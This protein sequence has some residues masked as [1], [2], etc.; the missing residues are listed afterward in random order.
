MTAI[1]QLPR[2]FPLVG[3]VVLSTGQTV[4]RALPA[5]T[6]S[7]YSAN[8]S[9]QADV[10]TTAARSTKHT[11]PVTA[12][13]TGRFP[14]IYLGQGISYDVTLKDS[15]GATIYTAEDIDGDPADAGSSVS[16]LGRTVEVGSIVYHSLQ[17]VPLGWLRIK[18]D[19]QALLKSSY[20]ELNTKYAA[21]GYPYGSA[22]TTFNI[23]GGAGLHVR[24]WDDTSTWDA[25][26][27]ARTTHA[28]G[29]GVVGNL[30]G[31]RQANQNKAHTHG[32]GSLGTD[33][34]PAHT[35]TIG[36]AGG[37]NSFGAANE[38]VGADANQATTSAAGA[39][40]HLVTTGVTGSDGGTDAR[41]DNV[42]FPLIILV[43]PALAAT[44]H[45]SLGFPYSFSTQTADS[46]PGPG[47]IR[48]NNASVIAATT[49]Y[50]AKT[51]AFG[52]TLTNVWALLDLIPGTARG[53]FTIYKASALGNSVTGVVTGALV[54]GGNYWKIPVVI[55]SSNGTLSDLDKLSV[56]FALNGQSGAAGATGPNSGLDYKF[57][58]STADS[59]PGNG[60]IRANN[61]T[62][63]S[64]TILYVS[65][66]GRNSEALSTL[67]D[68]L[69][70][71]SNSGDKA[72]LR[73]FTLAD[74]TKFLECTV[75]AAMTNATNYWKI[76]ITVTG[77]GT[78]PAADDILCFNFARTGNSATTVTIQEFTAGGTW[79]KPA[80][81]TKIRRR[82]IGGG[83]GGGGVTGVAAN[84]GAA[85]GGG[86][87][88]EFDAWQDA[89]SLTSE[90]VTIGAGGAGGAAGANNG[91]A[92][93]TTSFG[94]HASCN[95]GAAGVGAAAGTTAAVTA[96]AAG[97]T[98][99]STDLAGFVRTGQSSDEGLRWS[100]TVGKSGKGAD[101]TFGIGGGAL[102]AAGTGLVA[103]GF[104]AGGGGAF[105]TAA[106]NQAGGA[107][108]GGYMII[109]EYY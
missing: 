15:L 43:N 44:T 107:G 80:G 54:D 47:V 6:L 89:S 13:S 65:K 74:R 63:A 8:T 42:A 14:T 83:A 106:V 91:T 109:E 84:V 85:S 70:A 46:D 20:P 38:E 39:H 103:S 73:I 59:D 30:I 102:T 52:S 34:E 33:T 5:A 48:F 45:S 105:S 4:P 69:D 9:T 82:G 71:S 24:I 95:G 68:T 31:S 97:G 72:A 41:P 78:T 101:S 12:D 108:A 79:T 86:A 2:A 104:G 50:V 26:S 76:P 7:F 55:K 23:P 53:I 98:A 88:G 29:V 28:T 87:G 18:K 19:P 77:S 67:L 17:E 75:N 25:D 56:Q 92:G 40:D 51:D 21:Q 99:S 58:T 81:C 62:L 66:T 36:N 16:F 64:A 27:A 22:S 35:H 93:G 61:A 10:Y 57:A 94:A 96:A 3:D 100:G 60:Y 11:W 49:M 32:P 37:T 1:F 90:T